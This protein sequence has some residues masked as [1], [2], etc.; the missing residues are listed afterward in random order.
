MKIPTIVLQILLTLAF[1]L[2][3]GAKLA[4]V[5]VMIQEFDKVGFGQWFRYVTGCLEILGAVGLW[6]PRRSI[7]AALLLVCVMVGALAA[8]L[9]RIGGDPTA[10]LVLLALSGCVVWLRRGQLRASPSPNK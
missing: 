10:A 2:A 6:I 5:P 7:Y 9:L 3:G 1:G 4:G 8:H